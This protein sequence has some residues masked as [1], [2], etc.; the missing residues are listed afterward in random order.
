LRSSV[1]LVPHHG[2]KTSSTPAF[3]DAVAPRVAV[4]QAA[5]RSRFGHPAAEVVERYRQRGITLVRTDACGAW[6]WRAGPA[7]AGPVVGRA[8]TPAGG[9]AATPAGGRAAAEPAGP[10]ADA[11]VSVD[12]VVCQ[13][14]DARRYWHHPGLPATGAPSAGPAPPPTHSP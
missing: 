12:P 3:I 6:T 9:A 8:T 4:V 2:S 5:Y 10:L 11:V 7:W 1:L 14:Q 13:R